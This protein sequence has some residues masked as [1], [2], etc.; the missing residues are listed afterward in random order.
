[1]RLVLGLIALTAAAV[2]AG[3]WLQHL[4]GNLSLSIGTLQVQ[5]PLSV[6]IIALIVI[7]IAAYLLLRLLAT[8][9]HLPGAFRAR[10]HHSRRRRGDAA[11]TD[12]LIAL[13]AREPGDAKR[14]AARA[15]RLLGD[16]PQTLLLA[17][18]AG[19]IAGDTG[20]AEA[21]FEK[22]AERNDA[23]FLGLRGLLRL[24]VDRGDLP[25]ALELAREAEK[26]QP[27][28]A[29]LREE[30][31]HL[32]VLTNDWHEALQLTANGPPRA[33]I[34]A[35]AAEK[36]TDPN[37]ARKIAKQAW[38]QDPSLPA[39]AIAY[40]RRL[41][42]AGRE[43]S[44]QDVLRRT[45]AV[46][47]HPEIADIALA[48][49]VDKMERL[50][51]GTALVHDS[52]DHP[53]SRLLLGRLALEAGDTAAASRHA[54]V[55]T[56]AGLNQR[57]LHMLHADIA[58]ADGREPDQR[59]ALRLAATADADPS[60]RCTSCGAT[61]DQWWPAC[62]VCHAVGKISWMVPPKGLLAAPQIVR[63]GALPLDPAG[64]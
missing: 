21:A 23:A 34:A 28:A 7:V 64:A 42:E 9:F 45:W 2:G 18:Y 24:A 11:V 32:A 33:A 15:R 19:S 30:R 59:H 14:E 8:I 37:T 53:E 35:A 48:P 62:P 49:G 13:A 27:G 29:W 26:A 43:K 3:W 41:R 47:P 17:A 54:Q 60:W 40:A 52:P 63:P 20:E 44:A 10:G 16:T 39:A 38:K 58:E 22:L 31:T 57:R 50:K 5:T 56:S 1:M 36:E 4:T 12:T 61:H 51:I 25:R 55:A 6:A 46:N